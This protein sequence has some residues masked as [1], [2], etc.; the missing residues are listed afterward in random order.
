MKVNLLDYINRESG[1]ATIGSLYQLEKLVLMKIAEKA[2]EE[3]IFN[4]PEKVQTY[5]EQ[6]SGFDVLEM[7]QESIAMLDA[8]A[9]VSVEN[10]NLTS[11]FQ[12]DNIEFD[13]DEHKI[14]KK[15]DDNSEYIEA[16]KKMIDTNMSGE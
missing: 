8:I 13:L 6:M 1:I 9:T 15:F 14:L 3:S 2:K 10:S 5:I 16:Y 12:A 7:M 11:I 4:T